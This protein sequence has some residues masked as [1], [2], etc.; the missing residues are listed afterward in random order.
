[1]VENISSPSEITIFQRWPKVRLDK[2]AHL[3]L[4]SVDK[5][6]KSDELPVQLCNYTD[7][8]HNQFIMQDMKFM[9][10][11]ATNREIVKCLLQFRDVVITKDGGCDEI[12]SPAFV[13]EDITNLVC[14]YHLAI[15]R[16]LEEQI[17]GMYLFYALNTLDSKQQFRSRANGITIFGIRKQDIQEIEIPIPPMKEQKTIMAILGSLDDKIELNRRMN[18]SLEEMA[19]WLFKSWFVDF[20][21]VRAKMDGRWQ[22]G[23][24]L[25]GLPAELYDLFP[26]RLVSS[27]LGDVPENWT[28]FTLSEAISVNPKRTLAKGTKAPYLSMAN[29][30][31]N[32]STPL[33]TVDRPYKS[34]MKFSN[35]DTIVARI[36]PC[37]ENGK[38]AFVSFLKDGEVGWGSTEYI[39]MKPKLPLPDE[40]AYCLARTDRFRRFAITNMTGTS[41]RQRVSSKVIEDYQI[42]IPNDTE[43]AKIFGSLIKPLLASAQKASEESNLLAELRD[44]LLPKLISGEIRVDELD[45]EL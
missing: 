5:K 28:I 31:T 3:I 42:P 22:P 7:V 20:D 10:A 21:P 40:F 15:L 45:I 37:L 9:K 18:K 38:T 2:V 36:T 6:S 19:R 16:P 11:T 44:T 43:I 25:P 8:L 27:E 14:G 30:P 24:T 4:S 13:R 33:K 23:Q 35:G 29:M 39:V 1:M 41:G 17:Q 32:G 34:G 26:N 12:G